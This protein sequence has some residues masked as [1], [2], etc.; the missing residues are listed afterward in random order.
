MKDRDNIEG[1]TALMQLKN[2]QGPDIPDADPWNPMEGIDPASSSD[3][4]RL[5]ESSSASSFNQITKSAQTTG[6]REKLVTLKMRPHIHQERFLRSTCK[7]KTLIAGFRGGKTAIGATESFRK[8]VE[9]SRFLEKGIPAIG[10][11]VAPSYPMLRDIALRAVFE[12][13]PQ[14]FIRRWRPSEMRLECANGMDVLF[15]PGDDERKI[16]GLSKVAW[17]WIDEASMVPASSMRMIRARVMDLEGPIWATTTPRGMD[18]VYEWHCRGE[19]ASEKDFFTCRYSSDENPHVPF[20]EI[21][22]YR[23]TM[24]YRWVAQNID[25]EFIQDGTGVF[26]VTVDNFIPALVPF[27]PGEPSYWGLDLARYHDFTVLIGIDC[28]KQVRSFSRWNDIGWN[29]QK[30]RIINTVLK[31]GSDFHMRVDATGVGDPIV[32]DLQQMFGKFRVKGFTF[33]SNEKKVALIDAHVLSVEDNSFRW[34]E[35]M[36]Q[37]GKAMT[38]EY[39]AYTYKLSDKTRRVIYSAPKGQYDDCP[40]AGALADLAYREHYEK[41]PIIYIGTTQINRRNSA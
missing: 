29:S 20:D 2:I 38:L 14:D 39:K 19:D 31:S 13:W 5:P 18:W 8:A 1:M 35:E 10:L 9:G 25:A 24:P 3:I 6:H 4:Q 17:A 40:S 28:N 16:A 23:R 15:R 36:G 37:Y 34:P 32:A 7:Y 21:Q 30:E 33:S 26:P 27:K 22:E 41:Q 11:I 12:W